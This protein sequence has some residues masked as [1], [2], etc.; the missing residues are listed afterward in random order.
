MGPA[1]FA[2]EM[3][4]DLIESPILCASPMISTPCL[5]RAFDVPQW[6]IR[7]MTYQ[8][9]WCIWLGNFGTLIIAKEHYQVITTRHPGVYGR[10]AKSSFDSAGKQ[11][12]IRLGNIAKSNDPKTAKMSQISLPDD[13]LDERQRHNTHSER[14]E[15]LDSAGICAS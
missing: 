14:S 12:C 5:E 10:G 6:N 4:G 15:L 1:G 9:I 13:T 7:G 11:A 3:L 8:Q 2:S